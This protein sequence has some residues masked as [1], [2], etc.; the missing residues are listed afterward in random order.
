MAKSQRREDSDDEAFM[1]QNYYHLEGYDS[2]EFLRYRNERLTELLGELA[3]DMGLDPN[4]EYNRQRARQKVRR[5]FSPKS[6]LEWEYAIIAEMANVAKRRTNA[7]WKYALAN[8]DQEE[9]Q[10]LRLEFFEFESMEFHYALMF[11][12][13]QFEI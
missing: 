1:Q 6:D 7:R 11:F 13:V 4:Q 12:Q 3:E 10:A 8:G 5:K 9:A 2:D